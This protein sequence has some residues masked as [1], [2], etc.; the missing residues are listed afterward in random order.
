MPNPTLTPEAILDQAKF[1]SDIANIRSFIR[2][3]EALGGRMPAL[4]KAVDR[5]EFAVNTGTDVAAAAA[6]TSL[7]LRQ[8]TDDLDR[9]CEEGP[10]DP[11]VCQAKVAR[12]WQARN[13]QWVL[14][15]EKRES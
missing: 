14:S 5:L 8:Y 13:V 2:A 4:T 12:T 10:E 6:E 9:A 1:K 3:I 11:F 7:A 15:W